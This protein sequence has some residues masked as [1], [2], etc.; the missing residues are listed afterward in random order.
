MPAIGNVC[1]E[2][3]P[4]GEG[5]VACERGELVAITHLKRRPLSSKEIPKAA[6]LPQVFRLR[7]RKAV[8]TLHG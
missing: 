1:G 4:S 3:S 8:G 6:F 2:I 5:L 7:P